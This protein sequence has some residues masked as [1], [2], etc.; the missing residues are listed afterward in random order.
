MQSSLVLTAVAKK[1]KDDPKQRPPAGP[2]KKQARFELRAEVEWM[3][4]IERQAER[5][6]LTVAAYLRLAAT[7]RLERDESEDPRSDPPADA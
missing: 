7:E 3:E 2:Q 4:R 5:F 1:R 6:G